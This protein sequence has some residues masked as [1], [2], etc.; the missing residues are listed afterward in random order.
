MAGHM[1][2]G[3]RSRILGALLAVAVAA[4]VPRGTAAQSLK[5]DEV[6][7][8]IG[9]RMIAPPDPVRGA[10][11]R[12]HLAYE[13]IA[14]NTTSLFIRLDRVE[15][16][17]RQGRVL[18]ALAGD[19]LAAMVTMHGGSG[20]TIAPGG[21]A[22]VFMD[23]SF[24]A[25]TPLPAE[26]AARIT[27]TRQL[28]GP[29]GKP[30]PFPATQ[31]L[32]ATV[33]F[34]APFVA[35]GTKPAVVIDPPLHGARWIVANGCC[36]TLTS[37][38]G[39]VMAVNGVQRTPERFAIDLLQLRP[40]GRLYTGDRNRL[41]SYPYFGVPVYAVADG[42]VVNLYDKAVEQVPGRP[43][44]GITPENIGGDMLVIDIG[45][46]NFA[47]FAHLKPGSLRVRL[48]DR[49]TRGQVIASLGNTGNTDAPHLHFHV[50]DGTSPLD[51]NGKPYVFRQFAGRGI[52]DDDSAEGMF[53]AGKPG[54]IKPGVMAGP[55]RD[56]LPLNGEVVDFGQ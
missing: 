22:I 53:V 34:T 38:R 3:G 56:E 55:H 27:I 19:A 49:V 11:G 52:L 29:D 13:L 28:V 46:G 24:A 31:P 17:D 32:P 15:A 30:A 10:D 18:G 25:G 54:V 2:S 20:A 51:A 7:S 37:H 21:S 26:I 12:I 23:T 44:T 4:G 50:M 1:V 48:G 41:E 9:V 47:F 35:V 42:T 33:R 39:A 14:G 5:P 45:G 43:A 8:S 6:L 16:V 40:D 36:D